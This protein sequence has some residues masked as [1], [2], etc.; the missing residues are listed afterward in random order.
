MWVIFLVAII[1]AV[2]CWYIAKQ[3]NRNEGFAALWGF[4][5]P[6]PALIVYSLLEPYAYCPHCK[7]RIKTNSNVCWK[8]GKVVGS[9]V[10]P[11]MQDENI[12][13]RDKKNV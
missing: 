3:K 11:G 7:S 2:L 10:N 6:L 5:F 1:G 13:N 8:C 4:L 9:I 12:Q